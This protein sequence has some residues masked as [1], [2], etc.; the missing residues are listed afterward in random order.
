MFEKILDCQNLPTFPAIATELLELTR[1]PEVSLNDIAKLIRERS[2]A[3]QPGT[4]DGQFQFL[5]P[6]SAVAPASS[7]L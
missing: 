3:G 1:D 4:E 7:G 2:G 6:V 5:R